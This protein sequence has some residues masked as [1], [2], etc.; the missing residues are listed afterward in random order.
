MNISVIEPQAAET[1][2]AKGEV[3]VVLLFLEMLPSRHMVLGQDMT[4]FPSILMITPVTGA[5]KFLSL[6]RKV[7][8]MKQ[9]SSESKVRV[10][11][12][13]NMP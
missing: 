11:L 5:L 2:A 9:R 8:E 12:S 6:S 7:S 4:P 1:V 10:Y 3:L 13:K